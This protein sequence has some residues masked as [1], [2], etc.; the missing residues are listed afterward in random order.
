MN[1]KELRAI[2]KDNLSSS[3]SLLN[4]ALNGENIEYLETSLARLG[5]GRALPHWY[6]NLKENHVL[7]NLDGKTIGSVVEML[8]LAVLE[9]YTLKDFE[10][11]SF[12][13]N[14]AKGVDF[15]DLDLGMKSPS[16]NYCTSEPFF[17]AYERLLGSEYDCIVLLTNYQDAKKK[18]PLKLQILKHEY[19]SKTELAD[20]N[21]CS[22]ARYTRDFLL[23]INS[24]YTKKVF[25]FL[26]YVNQQDWQGRQ[27]LK[28]LSV[29][30]SKDQ[31]ISVYQDIIED[32][33][34][35]NNTLIRKEKE[36]IAQDFLDALVGSMNISPYY[37]GIVDCAD[38]WVVENLKESGRLPNDNE[39]KRLLDSP[40]DGR[41]G[42]SF[43]LQW[44]YNFGALFNGSS[45]LD[46]CLD[47]C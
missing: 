19:L 40:L 44:R 2:V 32:F 47:D 14:P 13:V 30:K 12:S 46:E 41:I 6:Q 17:S 36:P 21:I 29:I 3:V 27:I 15:P 9:N 33:S 5:R 16:T 10:H 26:C 39:W 38:N 31:C 28:L 8:F 42:M 22:L 18:P 4:S 37:L 25:R 45:E 43:A 1:K 20:R 24:S 34:R 7:P 23:E 35:Y 11:R